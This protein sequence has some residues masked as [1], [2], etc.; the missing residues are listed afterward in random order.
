MGNRS[1]PEAPAP[2]PEVDRARR[3]V[4]EIVAEARGLLEDR[5]GIGDLKIVAASVREMRDAFRLFAPFAGVRKVS[6]F[7]SARV[8]R[9]DPTYR[10]AVAFSHHIAEAGFM[11]ITG[12]GPGIMEACQFGAGRERSFGINIQLPFEQEP[13][14]IIHGDPK[15]MS[16]KYFFVRKLIFI[17]EAEAAVFFPGGFGTHDEGF[18]TLTLLQTGKSAPF[19]VVFLDVPGGTY[20][21]TW[22]RYVEEHLLRRGM[23]SR[24]DLALFKVTDRVEEA[25]RE[26]TDF[27]RVYHSS[28]YVRETLVIRL[29]R[30]V[31]A[32]WLERL[33]AEFADIVDS[34]KLALRA[35]YPVEQDEPDLW[36]LPRL[37]FH[38]KR[39]SLGR[40]RLFIDRLN[41]APQE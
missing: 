29:H 21:K 4:D 35:A 31:P 23:I 15:L 17:K 16:F 37:A 9:D 39:S 3:L 6:T 41:E 25:V 18:E 12:G 2:K 22:R 8:E 38:F 20:W 10:L 14:P 24:E 13:N 19:P 28:R 27:Y 40:L 36:H 7:G 34:G 5:A 1:A 30:A 26:I 32:A 11:V 33:S